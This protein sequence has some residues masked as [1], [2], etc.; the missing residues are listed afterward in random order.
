MHFINLNS[1]LPYAAANAVLKEFAMKKTLG[2]A[3][4]ALVAGASLFAEGLSVNGD[5]RSGI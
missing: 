4:A 3:A 2:I 5:I 1:A